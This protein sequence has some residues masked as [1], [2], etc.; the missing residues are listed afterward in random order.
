MS[1]IFNQRIKN[2][3]VYYLYIRMIV[4]NNQ[5][6]IKEKAILM[7]NGKIIKQSQF[8]HN[9]LTHSLNKEI[10]KRKKYLEKTVNKRKML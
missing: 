8:F 7:R 9:E 4:Y 2:E 1:I 3:S 10:N 5:K 6:I